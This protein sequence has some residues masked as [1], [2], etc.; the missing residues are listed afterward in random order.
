[1]AALDFFEWRACTLLPNSHSTL[2]PWQ[3]AAGYRFMSRTVLGVF[4]VF[5]GQEPGMY[6]QQTYLAQQAARQF[7]TISDG[8]D[9]YN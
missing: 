8:D 2:A 5:G 3:S 6:P 4:A 9:D 7:E 1:M